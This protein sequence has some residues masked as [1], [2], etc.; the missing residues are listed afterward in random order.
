M[1]IMNF[2]MTEQ[3]SLLICFLVIMLFIN[4]LFAVVEFI[5]GQ[6][7]M[8]E[9]AIYYALLDVLYIGIIWINSLFNGM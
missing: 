4:A 8:F 3:V 2:I 1:P 5:N 9:T 6:C 7:S